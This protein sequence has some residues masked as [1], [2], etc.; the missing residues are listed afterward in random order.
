MEDNWIEVKV[1]KDIIY[2]SIYSEYNISINY[3]NKN[4]IKIVTDEKFRYSTENAVPISKE[5]IRVLF[6]DLNLL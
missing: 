1:P 4:G 5:E 6:K 2:P 3:I